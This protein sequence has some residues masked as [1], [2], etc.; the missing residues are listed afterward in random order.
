M[1]PVRMAVLG[2]GF[3]GSTHLKALRDVPGAKLT[4][5]FSGYLSALASPIA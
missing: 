2:L 1:I 4:A 5:V 3:M